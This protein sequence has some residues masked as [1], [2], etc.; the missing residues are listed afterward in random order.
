[1]AA[2][3]AAA[4]PDGAGEVQPPQQ[5]QLSLDPAVLAA[6]GIDVLQ[7]TSLLQSVARA[8]GG[9]GADAA[10]GA[11]VAGGAEAGVDPALLQ[12]LLAGAA[13]QAAEAPGAVVEEDE[14]TEDAEG[15]VQVEGLVVAPA[16]LEGLGGEA[17]QGVVQP[18]SLW[19]GGGGGGAPQ[20]AGEDEG[21]GAGAAFHLAAHGDVEVEAGGPWQALQRPGGAWEE[22]EQAEARGDGDGT[23]GRP[24]KRF[25]AAAAVA[26]APRRATTSWSAISAAL[27]VQD[28]VLQQQQQQ[29]V[30]AGARQVEAHAAA[31]GRS[32]GGAEGGS[33]GHRTVPRVHVEPASPASV[34]RQ[35]ARIMGNRMGA[36]R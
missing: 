5:Q 9:G 25:A 29:Q 2:A 1:M 6:T 13:Q 34:Q 8:G 20:E 32:P 36:H 11:A 7:L 23:P 17:V 24:R 3:N 27:R 12:S 22:E 14:E 30:E 21:G 35:Q 26:A 31:V 16:A 10:G 15:V 19:G 28:L 33:A 4:A 18:G